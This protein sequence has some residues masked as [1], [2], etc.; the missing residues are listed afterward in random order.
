MTQLSFRKADPQDLAKIIE[1]VATH[2]E[3]DAEAIE[4]SLLATNFANH[5]CALIDNSVVGVTGYTQQPGCDRTFYLSWTYLHQKYCGQ[6]YGLQLMK[7][8]LTE[9]EAAGARKV[10]VKISDYV[11]P[12]EGAVYAAAMALYKKL[13]FNEE[14]TLQNY[15]A[16]NEA[17]HILGLTLVT[18]QTISEFPAEKPNLKFV[19]LY[20]V[21]ETEATYSFEWEPAKWWKGSFSVADVNIGLQAAYDNKAQQVVLSFPSTYHKAL[22]TL[23]S[24]GFE[25]VGSLKNYYEDGIDE[26]HYQYTF[27]EN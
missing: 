12:D 9:I 16:E 26:V 22:Q 17:M 11:D 15:Y 25:I 18:P 1:L 20:C 13:G 6:G 23:L 19:G 21:S 2:D 5:Y 27:N 4:D 10:F 14:V 3:D 8:I 7:Y 24:A